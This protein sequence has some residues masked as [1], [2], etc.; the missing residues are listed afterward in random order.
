MNEETSYEQQLKSEIEKA[1][2][3]T[4]K[5]NDIKNNQETIIAHE[6][7]YIVNCKAEIK[8]LEYKILKKVE[9]IEKTKES[10]A[11]LQILNLEKNRKYAKE[12]G[13]SLEELESSYEKS[14]DWR[15][16]FISNQVGYKY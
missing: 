15:N 12:N 7:N 2:S 16:S 14:K 5:Y 3:I 13:I 6:I 11:K 1:Y 10:I 9:S 8:E 4:T